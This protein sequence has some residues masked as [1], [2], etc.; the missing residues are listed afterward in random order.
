MNTCTPTHPCRLLSA[1]PTE[2]LSPLVVPAGAADALA[3]LARDALACSLLPAGTQD[4]AL[5]VLLQ[6]RPDVQQV[7]AQ[8]DGRGDCPINEAK[9]VNLKSRFEASRECPPPHFFLT[10]RCWMPLTRRRL[11]CSSQ[12]RSWGRCAGGQCIVCL[13]DRERWPSRTLFGTTSPSE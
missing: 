1:L 5:A 12:R 9:A 2:M 8:N 11:R 10:C 13:R 6:L 7:N 4:A 3:A